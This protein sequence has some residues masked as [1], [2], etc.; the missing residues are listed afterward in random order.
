MRFGFVSIFWFFPRIG[1]FL[2]STPS[3]LHFNIL[4]WSIIGGLWLYSQ[5][6]VL[7]SDRTTVQACDLRICSRIANH[8]LRIIQARWLL[9]QWLNFSLLV[10]CPQTTFNLP[11]INV[12]HIKSCLLS[13]LL[14]CLINLILLAI[15]LL[16]F[17]FVSRATRFFSRPKTRDLFSWDLLFAL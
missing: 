11:L 13:T 10:S 6:L 7:T 15:V 8:Y 16:P 9:Y 1:C 14:I 3:I 2:G 5:S 12:R 4:L 17:G